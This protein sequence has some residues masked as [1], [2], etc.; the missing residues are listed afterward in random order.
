MASCI[1]L[2][3]VQINVYINSKYKKKQNRNRIRRTWGTLSVTLKKK[4]Q[5]KLLDLEDNRERSE[6]KWCLFLKLL[7]LVYLLIISIKPT[8]GVHLFAYVFPTTMIYCS[9]YCFPVGTW[10]I[11]FMPTIRE[12]EDAL[13]LVSLRATLQLSVA[14]IFKW[15][16]P[17]W[18]SV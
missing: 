16:V 12:R 6:D 8:S 10:H 15:R 2:L 14:I 18:I 1:H 4:C 11:K 9:K 5:M 17:A 7:I 13:E 3:R